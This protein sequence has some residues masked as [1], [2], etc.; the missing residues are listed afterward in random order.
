MPAVVGPGGVA[1]GGGSDGAGVRCSRAV[2]GWGEGRAGD[3][4][5]CDMGR[6]AGDGADEECGAGRGGGAVVA[7]GRGDDRGADRGGCA[8]GLSRSAAS[9]AALAAE[10]ARCA[11][12]S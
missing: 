11:S 2:G 3:V 1:V 9:A 7:A 10:R 5:A 8:A 12:S 6:A 4:G